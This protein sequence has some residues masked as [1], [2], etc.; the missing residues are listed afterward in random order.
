MLPPDRS[1]CPVEFRI[2]TGEG[3]LG[4]ENR[5]L[6]KKRGSLYLPE[7][8]QKEGEGPFLELYRRRRSLFPTELR[9]STEGENVYK[10]GGK[11]GKSQSSSLL[12]SHPTVISIQ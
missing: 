2:F 12:T 3:A 7:V 1:L 4:K 6:R 10:G 11:K 5:K 9:N 8:P